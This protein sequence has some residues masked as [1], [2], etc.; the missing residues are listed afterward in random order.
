[1]VDEGEGL[2]CTKRLTAYR[3]INGIKDPQAIDIRYIT[4]SDWVA[5]VVDFGICIREGRPRGKI[6]AVRIARSGE[7]DPIA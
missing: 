7:V 3:R 2:L 6:R 1:M 4:H 5:K